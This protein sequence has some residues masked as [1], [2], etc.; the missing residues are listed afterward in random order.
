VPVDTRPEVRNLE[1]TKQL[2]AAR[3]EDDRDK[4]Q[5]SKD[6]MKEGE[7]P[8]LSEVRLRSEDIPQRAVYVLGI[9]RDGELFFSFCDVFNDHPY[10]GSV[11]ET[12]SASN[13]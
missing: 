11:R 4:N 9:I 12:T 5:D 2:G 13:K 1:R 10:M 7:E 6:K 8:R 3:L